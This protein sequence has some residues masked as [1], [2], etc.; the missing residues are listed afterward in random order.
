MKHDCNICSINADK[1]TDTAF[2]AQYGRHF[3]HFVSVRVLDHRR[4][5]KGSMLLYNLAAIKN[6]KIKICTQDKSR[7]KQRNPTKTML[8]ASEL[9]QKGSLSKH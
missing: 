6:F 7:E 3:H 4:N 5:N 8:I 1:G 9:V 2:R